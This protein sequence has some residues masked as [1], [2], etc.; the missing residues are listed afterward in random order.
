[1]F[2]ELNAKIEQ[3]ME[4]KKSVNGNIYAVLRVVE[5][6]PSQEFD[7]K[8]SLVSFNETF[9]EK[10]I[11]LGLKV[12]DYVKIKGSLRMKGVETEKGWLKDVSLLAN[13][14][15]NLSLNE[16]ERMGFVLPNSDPK[17]KANKYKAELDKPYS[18]KHNK[19]YKQEHKEVKK[20]FD[21]EVAEVETDQREQ[22]PF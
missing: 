9:K 2:F 12:G 13:D 20:D 16:L 14:I 10:Y 7:V 17:A 6:K 19:V 18:R 15:E 11:S 22:L 5:L 4:L 1:M 8:Y 3:K 21:E